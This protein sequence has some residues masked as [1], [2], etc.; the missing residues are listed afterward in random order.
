MV[1]GRR[2]TM[3][4]AT[5]IVDSGRSTVNHTDS[6]ESHI[7][8]HATTLEGTSSEM[9]KNSQSKTEPRKLKLK[10][11]NLAPKPIIARGDGLLPPSPGDCSGVHHAG[12]DFN[13]ILNH[14]G[15]DRASLLGSTSTP[16][17][18]A[19]RYPSTMQKESGS[20]RNP[21]DVDMLQP[22]SP[23][24]FATRPDSY[25]API[26]LQYRPSRPK[27][28]PQLVTPNGA[29]VLSGKVS[30]HQSHD[31]YK[32]LSAR[33]DLPAPVGLKEACTRPPFN[34]GAA[35]KAQPILSG[36]SDR[37]VREDQFGKVTA[38]DTGSA[39]LIYYEK[40]PYVYGP[41]TASHRTPLNGY[42]IFPNQHEELLRKKAVQYVLDHSRPRPRK[43]RLPDD[44]DATSGSEYEEA[45]ETR[46][47]RSKSCANGTHTN[48]SETS[49]PSTPTTGVSEEN[50]YD[51]GL[52]L[53]EMVEHTQL[54]TALFM[55]Y[56]CSPDHKGLREDIAMLASV[57]NRRLDAWITTEKHFDL[58]TRKRRRIFSPVTTPSPSDEDI[59]E[60]PTR[61][62]R[63]I[64]SHI[65]KKSEVI[66]LNEQMIQRH[67]EKQEK[68]TRED[69]VRR[70]I[71]ADSAVWKHEK[72][73]DM[74]DGSTGG[75]QA[76]V[77]K[78]SVASEFMRGH[79][80]TTVLSAE[81]SMERSTGVDS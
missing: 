77:R 27:S 5:S 32:M 12:T 14:S 17:I 72:T 41:N 11:R 8:G 1:K 42:P 55:A 70:Y 3:S 69:E 54:L 9:M 29:V 66:V 64:G 24:Q 80:P 20:A 57:T 35:R 10:L 18:E 52:R 25:Y 63:A 2:G 28:K 74:V 61:N 16:F 38:S 49:E 30:G 71:S 76:S 53:A 36:A 79:D 65:R 19:E 37:R 56:Q 45:T 13:G 62:S 22:S 46:K 43:R 75:E 73:K 47:T 4:S 21:I 68:R 44:P 51:R 15:Q 7:A 78:D 6:S 58:E 67:L 39:P 33:R 50:I 59:A 26:P 40:S 48:M 23:H 34:S 31:I 81:S 60:L